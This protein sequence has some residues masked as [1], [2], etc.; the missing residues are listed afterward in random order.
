MISEIF[1]ECK[2]LLEIDFFLNKSKKYWKK[3]KKK[4]IKQIKGRMY[5]W[6]IPLRR[7]GGKLIAYGLL[8]Y[9]LINMR[10]WYT[11]KKNCL[12]HKN[13]KKIDIIT[14]LNENYNQLNTLIEEE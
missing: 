10:Q 14:Y 3:Y 8:R 7:H 2:E 6:S 11:A 5:L 4:K 12:T 1:I 9:Y 13:F